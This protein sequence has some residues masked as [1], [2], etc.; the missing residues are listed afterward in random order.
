[1]QGERKVSIEIYK[2]AAEIKKGDVVKIKGRT[3]SK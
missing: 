2:K 3:T 1:M